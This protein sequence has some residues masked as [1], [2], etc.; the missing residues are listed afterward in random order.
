MR[1]LLKCLRRV[2]CSVAEASAT[3]VL[4]RSPFTVR[5]LELSGSA[6]PGVPKYERGNFCLCKLLVSDGIRTVF[7]TLGCHPIGPLLS[8]LCGSAFSVGFVFA[9]A[10][11]PEGH[12]PVSITPTFARAVHF[13]FAIPRE[14]NS[15]EHHSAFVADFPGEASVLREKLVTSLDGQQ[16]PNSP[17]APDALLGERVGWSDP[18][19][20][21]P[22]ESGEKWGR[23]SPTRCHSEAILTI[24]SCATSSPSGTCSI[25]KVNARVTHRVICVFHAPVTFPRCN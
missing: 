10:A 16:H 4:A 14:T 6:G 12:S 9:R 17:S 23:S 7:S 3:R 22:R 20:F 24:P 11:W 18:A 1:G 25:G 15:T 21:S 8:R 2:S 13:R 19:V 5:Q